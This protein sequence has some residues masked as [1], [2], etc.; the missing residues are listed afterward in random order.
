MRTHP[1]GQAQGPATTYILIIILIAL[2]FR[3]AWI[4]APLASDELANASIWAQMPFAKIVSNYQYPNNHIFLTLILAGI[5]KVFG[6]DEIALRLPVLLSGVL[7][8][9]IGYLTAIRMSRNMTVALGTSLLLAI[10]VQHIYYSTNARGYMLLMVFAQIIFHRALVWSQVTDTEKPVS[11]KDCVFLGAL[12]CLGTW[13]V[14]TFVLFEV[15]LGLYFVSQINLKAGLSGVAKSHIKILLTLIL[16]LAGFYVQYYVLIA[17]AMLKMGMANAMSESNTVAGLIPSILGEWIHPC[18]NLLPVLVAVALLGMY[19]VCNQNR[20]A[21]YLLMSLLVI[22]PATSIVLSLAKITG[23]PHARVFMYLQP[24]FFLLLAVGAFYLSEIIFGKLSISRMTDGC[25]AI[26][27]LP[28]VY[29]SA[30]ELLI[31]TYPERQAREPY[32]KVLRFMQNLGPADLVIASNKIH[33]GFYLYGA[34]EMRKRVDTI[35]DKQEL[36]DIY[37]LTYTRNKDSDME[38]VNVAGM[39]YYKFTDHIHIATQKE[40]NKDLL[41]PAMMFEQSVHY[42]H[43][44]IYKVRRQYVKSLSKIKTLN[45][46]QNWAGTDKVR[47]EPYMTAEGSQALLRFDDLIYWASKQRVGDGGEIFSLNIN[48]LSTTMPDNEGAF[49]LNVQGEQIANSWMANAWTMDHPYGS[50]IYNRPWNPVVYLSDSKESFE[51]I[52]TQQPGKAG[53]IRGVQSYRFA[54]PGN[55]VN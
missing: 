31:H 41:I 50:A 28:F 22:P 1:Q 32:D 8:V 49:Y 5:L 23:V 35:I 15:S 29:F 20:P 17:S 14:P 11:T 9:Y 44:D 6:V 42:D 4:S 54:L 25:F 52:R 10:S 27:F 34:S 16:C 19:R 47:V 45:D 46:M 30:S 33:V 2:A 12:C 48:L 13:T 26:L 3:L 51:T 7:S 43:F 53:A 39:D 18:E 38:K 24:M 37:F 21:F 40:Q 36:G 55:Q